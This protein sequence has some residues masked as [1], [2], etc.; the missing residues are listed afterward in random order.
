M[1]GDTSDMM[2]RLKV[3]LPAHWFSDST[4]VLDGVLTGLASTW[5]WIYRALAYS[6]NQTRLATATDTFL[7]AI[8]SD[9]LGAALPRR[10]QEPDIVYRPRIARELL[11]E[12]DTRAAVISTLLDLTGH[13][14]IIFEPARPADTGAW[15]GPLGYGAAG[16]WGSLILPFQ[17]FV[18]AFRASGSGIAGVIGYGSATLGSDNPAGGGYGVGAIEYAGIN[19]LTG[20]ITDIDINGAIAAVMPVATIGWTR[21]A[22]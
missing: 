22:N 12:R 5:S 9:F 1:L 13:L 14:P 17:C 19:M 18:T 4:P 20:Q 16:G 21:I 8:S 10:I 15:G 2:A 7:D 3:T 6:K 11:R